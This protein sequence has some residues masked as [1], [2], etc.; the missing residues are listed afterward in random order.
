MIEG[1]VGI[2]SQSKLFEHVLCAP[3]WA[4]ATKEKN[5]A[6]TAHFPSSDT[7]FS[8][9]YSLS[10]D[11]I[12]LSFAG[13]GK[14]VS[15]RILLPGWKKCSKVTLDGKKTGFK[16]SKMEKS[17]YVILDT[18]IKGARELVVTR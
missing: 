6:A 3:R 15:F 1:L 7:Y 11:S 18:E 10:R 12:R 8:Y 9:R 5:V 4:A 17:S 13:T 14:N 16:I 2:Q